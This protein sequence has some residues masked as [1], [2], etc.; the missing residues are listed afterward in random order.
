M[1]ERGGEQV[2]PVGKDQRGLLGLPWCESGMVCGGGVGGTST[3]TSE[4][5]ARR[6][7]VCRGETVKG[8]S[9]LFYTGYTGKLIHSARASLTLRLSWRLRLP[10]PCSGRDP[11]LGRRRT[12]SRAIPSLLT[13]HLDR[14]A[15]RQEHGILQPKPHT[16]HTP[17]CPRAGSVSIPP[18]VSHRD[19]LI[20]RHR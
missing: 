17:Q 15:F 18:L 4:Y 11:N 14:D 12:G 2:G 20:F 6:V 9:K 8:R 16:E 1:V 13:C 5:E 10:A 7:E 19:F 3:N